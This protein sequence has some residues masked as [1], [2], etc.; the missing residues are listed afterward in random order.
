MIVAVAIRMRRKI[1]SY[2]SVALNTRIHPCGERELSLVEGSARQRDYRQLI[3]SAFN[4]CHAGPAV[5][6]GNVA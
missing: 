1:K 2:P 4:L 5:G 3:T 6:I